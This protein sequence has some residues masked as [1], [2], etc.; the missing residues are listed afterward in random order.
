[1]QLRSITLLDFQAHEELDLK[2]SP[3]ITT[4]QGPTDAGK[5]SI[6]R[7]VR[8]ACLN[9]IGGDQ[10]IRE[11]AKRTEIKL[12][13]DVGEKKRTVTRSKGVHENLYA[14]DK[15]AME[16]FGRSGVPD[17]IA[18]LLRLSEINFQ[19]Q[20][21]SPFWFA[22]SAG[23]VSRQLNAV[24]DLT[25]IDTT[26]ANIA[27]A[28][29]RAKERHELTKERLDTAQQQL[30]ESLWQRQR[31]AQFET[32]QELWDRADRAQGRL[33][34]MTDLLRSVEENQAE[35]LH[36]KQLEA[37]ELLV[38]GKRTVSLTRQCENLRGLLQASEQASLVAKPPPNFLELEQLEGVWQEIDEQT[39]TLSELVRRG[40]EAYFAVDAK[41]AAFQ[42]VEEQFHQQTKGTKCPLC[43]NKIT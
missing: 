40:Q 9:D 35:A 42:A 4:I 16:A 8:W 37:E 30:E 31:I 17:P 39:H 22:E 36:D 7:A 18:D 19:G 24:V 1:M 27:T 26:L 2:L 11:G 21:D 38:W 33:E 41:L 28:V 3:T 13:I 32:L 10:F 43:G 6:L 5:S 34:E 20:H 25:V 29:R 15:Q 12:V 14:L 23:E